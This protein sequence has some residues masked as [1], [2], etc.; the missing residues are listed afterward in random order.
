MVR[1]S[2]TPWP[3]NDRLERL[4]GRQHHYQCRTNSELGNVALLSLK[5]YTL[6]DLRGGHEH[7]DGRWRLWVWG[8]NVGDVY[9]WTAASRDTDTTTRFA[10]RPATFGVTL[11]YRYR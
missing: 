6:V 11:Q 5:P 10:G 1:R 9:Y 3:L 8:R 2:T 4:R 7:P